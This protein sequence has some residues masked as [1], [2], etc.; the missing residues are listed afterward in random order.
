[1]R[2]HW[3]RPPK[4]KGRASFLDLSYLASRSEELTP[5]RYLGLGLKFSE[6][7]FRE[8]VSNGLGVTLRILMERERK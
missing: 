4:T 3:Q 8:V 1:M 2:R 6:V 5:R 7:P